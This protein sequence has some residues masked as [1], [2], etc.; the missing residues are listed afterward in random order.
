MTLSEAYSILLS[1][2]PLKKQ[3]DLYQW[4]LTAQHRTH[5]RIVTQAYEVIVKHRH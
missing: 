4:C 2:L 3:D 5:E 1:R